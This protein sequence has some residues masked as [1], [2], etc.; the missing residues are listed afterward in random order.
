MCEGTAEVF[1]SAVP[2]RFCGVPGTF[3]YR[4]C[5]DCG[6]VFQDPRVIEEDLALCYPAT[7]YT[8]APT[9]APVR[10]AAPPRRRRPAGAVRDA[11]RDAIRAAVLREPVH[12]LAGVAGRAM[13]AF[14]R[15]RVRAFNDSLPD[16]LLPRSTRPGRALDIGCGSGDLLAALAGAGWDAEGVD[17]DPA[18]AEAARRRTGL[19]VTAGDFRQLRLPAGAYHLILMSHVLEHLSSTAHALRRIGELLAP[20]GRAVLIYPNPAAL[21]AR[22][23]GP[24]WFGWDPPRHLV[25]PSR[26]A[27]VRSAR[28][29]GLLVV[30]ARSRF[31]GMVGVMGWLAASRAYRDGRPASGDAPTRPDRRIARIEQVLVKLGLGVGEDILAVLERAA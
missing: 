10:E 4:R 18:A 5:R 26:R 22:A 14:E 17:V 15:F 13:A 29:A 2:D 21:G 1:L 24:Y 19:P 23:F 25:L 9:E 7:Y 31:S 12:G 8:H 28:E 27:L 20:G 11:L 30:E 3:S 16:Q 6:S